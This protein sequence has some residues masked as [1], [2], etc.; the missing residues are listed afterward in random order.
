MPTPVPIETFL[1]MAARAPIVDVRT[2]SEFAQ[3]H[4]PT[5]H[6]VP[7][8]DDAGRAEV[9]RA[10]HRSGR[11]P[12]ILKGLELVAP[13]MREIVET[14]RKIAGDPVDVEVA[15]HC[16]R[17]GMRSRSVAWLLGQA[18]FRVA[19]LEGGYKSYRRNVLAHFE[20]RW[21]LVAL[22]GLT[23]VGKTRLIQEL[24]EHGEQVIDLEA[25]ARHRGSAFGGIGLGPQPTVEQFE[26]ELAWQL[27][28]CDVRRRIW[29]EDE[30]QRIGRVSLPNALFAQL[31]LAPAIFLE[32]PTTVRVRVIAAEYGAMPTAELADSIRA[33]DRRLGGLQT[34]QALAALETDDRDACIELLLNYYD[35]TYY[36]AKAKFRRDVCHHVPLLDPGLPAAAPTILAVADQAGL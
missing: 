2:P 8:F 32:V 29:M 1:E 15:V 20:R 30:S 10:Y 23:G 11:Y 21:P 17:G 35:R 31:K 4:I 36:A 34:Q 19:L 16:W 24:A 14:V 18:G 25:L 26:N 33:I 22:S 9:G 7:L 6:N 12:A 13:R 3:G 28:R 5:A 27:A